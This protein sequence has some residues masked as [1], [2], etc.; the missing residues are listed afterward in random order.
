MEAFAQFGAKGQVSFGEGCLSGGQV[1]F[2]LIQFLGGKEGSGEAGGQS[3]EHSPNQKDLYNVFDGYF[4]DISSFEED[5]SDK[6]F[7]L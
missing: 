7:S 5:A 3:F 1:V 4:G 2:D 6:S